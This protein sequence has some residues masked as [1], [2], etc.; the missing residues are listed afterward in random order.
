MFLGF[1]FFCMGL[2]ATCFMIT[3]RRTALS[4][5][6]EKLSRIPGVNKFILSKSRK[7]EATKDAEADN[8]AICLEDYSQNPNKEVAELGCDQRHLF[9]VECLTEWVKKNDICPMCR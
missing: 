6:R 2:Y 5:H 4:D 7:W 9:H 1:F 3:G 8:C